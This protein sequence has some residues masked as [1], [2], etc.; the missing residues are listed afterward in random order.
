MEELDDV[1]H[2]VSSGS[3]QANRSVSNTRSSEREAIERHLSDNAGRYWPDLSGSSSLTLLR[4]QERLHTRLYW[5]RIDFILGFREVVVK[6]PGDPED[7]SSGGDL[8]RP[9]LSTPPPLVDKY[10]LEYKALELLSRHFTALADPRFGAVPILDRISDVRGIVMEE[11]N[12]VRMNRLFMRL[13]RLHPGRPPD[14]LRRAVENAGAWLRQYHL[15]ESSHAVTRQS[16]RAEYVDLVDRNCEYLATALPARRALFA[17]LAECTRAA[18]MRAL[19]QELPLVLGH[20]DFAMRNL[21]VQ[22]RGRVFVLDT[23]ALW[24]EPAYEDIGRFLLTM[25]FVRPQVYSHGVFLGEAQLRIVG[26]WLL[27]GYYGVE[28]VPTAQ[29]RVYSV[30]LLLDMW[31]AEVGRQA[32]GPRAVDWVK[33]HLT[34]AWFARQARQLAA[35][36]R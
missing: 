23:L 15:L 22:P 4:T 8:G 24:R 31:S 34:N 29:I 5:Y 19:P 27:D 32:P 18:A 11:I 2:S 20:G 10:A 3:G 6:V 9:R 13:G 12:G 14:I 33:S 30:L 35:G 16:H 36:L 7:I 26:R 1:R 17:E 21:I 28:P 25:R